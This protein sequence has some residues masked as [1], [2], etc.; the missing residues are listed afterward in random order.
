MTSWSQ[1]KMMHR[2]LRA[3]FCCAIFPFLTISHLQAQSVPNLAAVRVATGLT[4]P[5]FVTAPPGDFERLFIV[6]QDGAI[7]ILN[8]TTGALSP[9]PFLTLNGLRVGGEQ[10]LLGM[11]FDPNYATNGKFYLNFVI[12][13]GAFGNGVTHVSQFSVTTNPN[14]ADPGSEKIL[15]T[16]DHPQAN[17]NGGWIA[18]SPRA[19]DA[20]NLYIATGDGGGGNDTGLGHIEP[21]GNA[22]SKG[23]VLGKMLR[24]HVDSGAG[25]ASIPPDNPF[26]GMAGASPEIW[27]YGLRNPFRNSFDRATG[28]LFIGDVGQSTREE[29]DVQKTVHPRGGENYGWRVREGSIQNPAYPGVPTPAGAVN[30]IVDYPRSIGQTVIGGYVYRGQQ[31]PQLRGTYIFADFAGPEF[32][33]LPNPNTGRVFSLNYNGTVANNFQDLTSHLFPTRAGGFP[34]GL[35]SSLG[36]DASGELYITDLSGSVFKIVPFVGASGVKA[37]FDSDGIADI[38]WQNDRDGRRAIWLMNRTALKS[39]IVFGTVSTQWSIAGTGDFNGDNIPDIL[40][41]NNATGERAIWLMNGTTRM[42]SVS[43][44]SVSAQWSLAGAADFNNDGND[45]ILW[46]NRTTG[47]RAIWLMNGHI[48]RSA[49]SLGAVPTQWSI[50]ASADFSGD[51]Q[52]DIVFENK[53]TGQRVIWVMSNTSHVGNLNLPNPGTDWSI[54]GAADFNGD[55]KPDILW[56]NNTTGRRAI[57]IMN[58]ASLVSGIY[59]PTVPT[60]WSVRNF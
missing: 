18:F 22:Q 20:N 15:L 6:Q 10:G 33:P 5:L 32:S 38:L 25:T 34:L 1:A 53:L 42:S 52:P 2:N 4:Q 58:G 40:W 50:V 30:P 11:A 31:I 12:P 47:A 16:F 44:P 24:I 9:T 60:E 14:I 23:T 35:P 46:Q 51:G 43:L 55:G 3:E 29:I 13:G 45:D 37:D 19:N 49:V 54:A 17:H 48:L 36:E 28:T 8:L 39:A 7:R 59:L 26:V 41:Q 57:W 56:Q 27:A 21:G